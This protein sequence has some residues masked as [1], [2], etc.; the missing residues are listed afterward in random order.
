MST[1]CDQI[2][3]GLFYYDKTG[4]KRPTCLIL[5]GH[6][7]KDFCFEVYHFVM[8]TDY[9]KFENPEGGFRK[10]LGLNVIVMNETRGGSFDWGFGD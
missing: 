5:S 2:A 10:F 4:R 9:A 3:M 1:I 8:K 7:A 6:F